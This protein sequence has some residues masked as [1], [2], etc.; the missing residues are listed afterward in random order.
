M[1]TNPKHDAIALLNESN[2]QSAVIDAFSAA[3]E[4]APVDKTGKIDL[5]ALR[6][7]Y[8]GKKL[9]VT[10]RRIRNLTINWV[11]VVYKIGTRTGG[12]EST[13]LPEHHPDWAHFLEALNALKVLSGSMDIKL[14]DK[15]AR[16]VEELWIAKK[17]IEA[18]SENDLAS[19]LKGHIGKDELPALL[20]SLEVL[21]IIY[22]EDGKIIKREKFTLVA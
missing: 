12:I 19:A 8:K 5:K 7:Q 10:S 4:N 13:P 1:M 18:I 11:E 16:I 14:G 20:G 3:L 15:S 22:R 21:G 17:N 2:I 9:E 6:A